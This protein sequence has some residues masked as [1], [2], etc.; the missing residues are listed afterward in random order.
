[1][2]PKNNSSPIVG[3]APWAETVTDYDRK[4]FTDYI[5]LLDAVAARASEEEMCR[6]VLGIDYAR[7]PSQ[8]KRVLDSHLKRAR[9]M[10]QH[11]YR[12]LLP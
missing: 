6:T 10:S 9:W 8:A 4:H 11:G 3:E 5:R 2:P 12:Q 1:M 7:D